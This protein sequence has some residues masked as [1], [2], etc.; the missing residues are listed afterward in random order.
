MKL[1]TNPSGIRGS[2]TANLPLE[3]H[4]GEDPTNPCWDAEA[5]KNF[6]KVV[7]GHPD[8]LVYTLNVDPVNRTGNDK[9]DL[10]STRSIC[11]EPINME[12]NNHPVGCSADRCDATH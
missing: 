10:I 12:A 6:L 2:L 7:I 4:E 11:S 8:N 5:S 9:G 1:T 3:A